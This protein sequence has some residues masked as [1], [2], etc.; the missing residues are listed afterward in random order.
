MTVRLFLRYCGTRF[1]GFQKQNIKGK[2][3]PNVCTVQGT[4]DRALRKLLKDNTISCVGCSRTDAGVHANMFVVSFDVEKSIVPP[5]N[6]AA[7]I[8]HLLPSDIVVYKSEIMPD[9]WNARFETKSKTYKYFFYT[10][11]FGNPV[12]NDRA[13]FVKAERLNISKMNEAARALVGTHNFSSFCG[14]TDSQKSM[15]RTINSL[16]IAEIKPDFYELSV[17]G[18]GFLYNM[19]RIITGTLVMVGEG[20]IDPSDIQKIIAAEDRSAAGITAP[21]D[22]LYL[23]EVFY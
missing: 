18:D 7:A 11:N 10:G 13:W 2:E 14:D 12:F 19:V 1:N 20:K 16:E 21:P 22:G 23:W 15:I 3:N 9:G 5:E 8:G 17:N 4:L 6:I